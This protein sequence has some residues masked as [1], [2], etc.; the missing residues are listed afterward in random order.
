MHHYEKSSIIVRKEMM[1]G[2]D[3]FVV[4]CRELGI[5]SQGSGQKDA[6][7]NIKDAIKLYLKEQHSV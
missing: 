6:I 7:K 2:K 5:T 1:N 3:V 4:D